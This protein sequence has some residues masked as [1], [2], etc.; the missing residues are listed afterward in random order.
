M[1]FEIFKD[2][3]T[4]SECGNFYQKIF[5]NAQVNLPLQRFKAAFKFHLLKKRPV[6]HEPSTNKRLDQYLCSHKYC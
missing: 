2:G 3:C 5:T 4:Q 6:L 1:L